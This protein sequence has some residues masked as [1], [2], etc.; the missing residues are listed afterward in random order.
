MAEEETGLEGLDPR[1][2]LGWVE[3]TT[4]VGARLSRVRALSGSGRLA[5][6]DRLELVSGGGAAPGQ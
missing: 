5:E 2:R 3:V 1:R 4:V 6:G